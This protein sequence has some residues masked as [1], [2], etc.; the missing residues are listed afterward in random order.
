[1]PLPFRNLALLLAAAVLLSACSGGDSSAPAPVQ[2][3]LPS[4]GS[5]SGGG[6]ARGTSATEFE[7][8]DSGPIAL[9]P[10]GATPAAGQVTLNPPDGGMTWAIYALGGFP[11]D[12]TVVPLTV[13]IQRSAPCWVAF[14]NY[15]LNRWE[16]QRSA[17]PGAMTPLSS[18]LVSDSG[19]FYVAV[20]GISGEFNPS[21][22]CN[23][24]SLKVTTSGDLVTP[25]PFLNTLSAAGQLAAEVPSFFNAVSSDPGTGGT[26]TQITYE[27]NDATPA[28]VTTDP[29][30]EVSH[31][32][33]DEGPHTVTLTVDNDL[34]KSATSNFI[35][36]LG[37]PFREMLVVYNSDI[38]ESLD[39]CTYYSGSQYG[40][41]IDPDYIVGLPLG[42]DAN[43]D[44]SRATYESTLRDPIKTHLDASGYKDTIKYI[45]LL[46]GVPHRISDGGNSASIDSELC[47]LYS[48]G[49]YPY[50][51]WLYSAPADQEIGT[52]GFYGQ[53]DVDF[54]PNTY[55]V[56]HD[57]TYDLPDSG[58]ETLATLSYLVGRLS[59][60]TYDEAKLL[61]GRSVGADKS[62]NGWAM[63]D[64]S[65]ELFG[66]PPNPQTYYDTMVDPVFKYPGST[67]AAENSL[68]ELLDAASYSNF[69]D[70]TSERIINGSA[71]LP[72]GFPN[73]VI[74]CTG[75]GVN[76][77]GGSWPNGANYIL[78]DLQWNY[79]PGAGWMSY[80]SYNGWNFNGDNLGNR[81]GQGQICDF[82][83]MGGTVAIGNSWEPYTIG[84]G[85]ERMVFNR[86][87]IEGDRWIE[88]A[89][90][91]LRLLSWM[92]VVVGDPLCTVK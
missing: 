10:L 27:W 45:L 60:Y 54:V 81:Q 77:A 62:G 67:D 70:T 14:S 31:T 51:I 91:G 59:A 9:D 57:P 53:G 22:Y 13:D 21:G 65:V 15:A 3:G 69:V 36:D 78:Q 33:P 29:L 28:D 1:M 35:I 86:Y 76:H 47:L 46:K 34:G 7:L 30:T 49:T 23:V 25:Q 71:T 73:E 4:L 84:V 90:K 82:F 32:W 75:W 40:R 68:Q 79:L 19:K 88:A 37:A 80:E 92:E 66:N 74:A 38:P 2:S 52:T 16:L 11:T 85:D 44:F 64:S 48:D 5:L 18:N 89:Y 41:S 61:V 42:I 39:L 26:I 56:S 50:D 6:L 63:I 8:L 24:T 43:A 12:G 72:P 58:D 20:I 87:L 55:V 83:R 17:A